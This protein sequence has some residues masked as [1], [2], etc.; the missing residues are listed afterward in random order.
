[1]SQ[2]SETLV[3]VAPK[4]HPR[5]LSGAAALVPCRPPGQA[6][7][8]SRPAA[9]GGE[10]PWSLPE[11]V[12]DSLEP[13][14]FY[15]R[16]LRTPLLTLIAAGMAVAALPLFVLILAVNALLHGGLSRAF[17][18]QERVGFRGRVFR[19]VK[20]RTMRDGDGDDGARV[21][22]FGRFLRNCHL[23]ELPQLIHVLRG[24][25]SL[26]GPRPEMVSIESWAVRHVPGFNRRLAL[27]PGITG[28][29]QITQGYARAG[30]EAAYRE[31]SR[32]NEDYLEHVSFL[33]DLGILVRTGLWMLRRRGW[34]WQDQARACSELSKSAR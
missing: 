2:S 7:E 10:V 31:K 18:L 16:R 3:P 24:E 9:E 13:S 14:G 33:G 26:I 15:A 25:M 30:N 32:R 12:W 6:R 5:G 21:T 4:P 20:F 19:V 23:D 22:R 8:R 27:R 1:M 34:R 17:F 29:A 28:W 11:E